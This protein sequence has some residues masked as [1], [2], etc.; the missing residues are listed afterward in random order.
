MNILVTICARGGSKGIPGKNIKLLA[1]VPLIEY[2][3]RAART[4]ATRHNAVIALST[5]DEAI[6]KAA[7]AA[8]ITSD[9]KRPEELAT[10]T[11][12]KIDT[13]RDLV[14][15]TEQ[16]NNCRYDFVLDLDVTSPLRTQEDIDKGFDIIAADPDALTLFSVNKANRN[17]Y[18]SMVEP[19]NG[20]YYSHV[21]KGSGNIPLSRQTA[22][23]AYDMNG[24][25]FWYRRVFFDLGGKS[26]V[27]ERSLIYEM[28]HVCFDLDHMIDFEFM[29]FLLTSKK[30][31]FEI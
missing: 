21:K 22:P 14:L 5:D 8:G 3:I 29:N 26:A 1:G 24:S 18:F 23:P 10:D 31:D 27:T 11:A 16:K 15:F 6:K 25:F 28:D 4:F 2:T 20:K 7:A 9:Y 12:G 17:P 30:L 13:I 19:G